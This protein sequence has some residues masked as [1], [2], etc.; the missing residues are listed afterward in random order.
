MPF[1]HSQ[2]YGPRWDLQEGIEGAGRRAHRATLHNLSWILVSWGGPR[3][4]EVSKCETHLQEELEGGSGELWTVSLTSGRDLKASQSPTPGPGQTQESHHV[5]EC[6]GKAN[7]CHC[8]AALSDLW[9][10]VDWGR[11]PIT[12]ERLL[13]Y[14]FARRAR[15]K[16]LQL[17]RP[18]SHRK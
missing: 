11:F 17:G 13:F 12:G 6:T 15:K 5:P 3:W 2:V 7:W 8:Q 14:P 1:R 18:L 16:W 10:T 9:Q 4:L